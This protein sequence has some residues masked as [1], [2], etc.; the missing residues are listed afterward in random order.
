[1]PRQAQPFLP[2]AQRLLDVLPH[3]QCRRCGYA[4]CTAYAQAMAQ[5]EAAINRCPPGGAEGIAR[6]AT[7]TGQAVQPLDADC[8]QEGPRNVVWIDEDWCI[9]CTL[10]IKACPV[11][12]I[13]G[14]NKY[15][16]T[17]READCTGCELCI[18]ACP[19]DCI[20]PRN[21]SGSATGRAAWSQSQALQA[22]Q[23][24]ERRSKRLARQ[25]TGSPHAADTPPVALAAPLPQPQ[26]TPH[27]RQAAIQAALARARALRG[28]P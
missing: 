2:L 25:E 5:G 23:R 24:Y 28:A 13:V 6:L 27:T 3:T 4:D 17:V 22:Q 21:A 26:E 9:G 15:M 12:A 18:P 19:V 8:G 20:I 14:A 16:H 10:C 1:M 7:I 11:D